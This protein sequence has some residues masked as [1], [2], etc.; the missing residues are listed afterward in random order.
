MI[1]GRTARCLAVSAGFLVFG[2]TGC[3]SKSTDMD[4]GSQTGSEFD[5]GGS[6][7]DRAGGSSRSLSELQTIYFDYDRYAIRADSKSALGANAEAITGNTAWG[8][9]TVE[10]HCDERGSEEYNLALGERRA[11]AVRRYLIDLGV[12]TSRLRTVSF[13]EARAAVPGHDEN[14]WRYNRR[15]EFKGGS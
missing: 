14:A 12:G 8:T 2:L 7:D 15:S 13:G 10:G 3:P 1:G 5:D 4:T 9:V 11:N 6:V